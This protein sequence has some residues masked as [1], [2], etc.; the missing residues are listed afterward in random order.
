VERFVDF[1]LHVENLIR[2]LVP[3][4]VGGKGWK[5]KVYYREEWKKLLRTARN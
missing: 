3:S 4:L 2:H 5:G 1:H